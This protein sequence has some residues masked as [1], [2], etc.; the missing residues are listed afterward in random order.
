LAVNLEDAEMNA[1]KPP[2][3]KRRAFNSGGEFHGEEK[4][5]PEFFFRAEAAWEA[6]Y[7]DCKDAKKSIWVEQYI[8]LNDRAG[9][10]F[11][12][13]FAEKAQEG[14]EVRVVLDG[15]GSRALAKD[16]VAE[17]LR[18]AGVKLR[19]YHAVGWR[20]FL[21]PLRCLP[22]T[23][24]K[25]LL[26]DDRVAWTGSACFREEMR[27]WHE[28]GARFTGP[29]VEAVR[30]EQE[31]FWRSLL[32]GKSA[33]EKRPGK[34]PL[35]YFVS[36]PHF[37][38]S[39]IYR[40]LV[41]RID[42]AKSHIRVAAPY[43]MPP[44]RLRK[45]LERAAARGVRVDVLLSAKTDVKLA[46]CV[47]RVYIPRLLQ[48]GVR[49]YL[50][51]DGVLHAKFV[52]VDGLFAAVGSVNLD[53][54]S[55]TRNREASLILQGY[56]DVRHLWEYSNGYIRRA[57]RIDLAWWRGLPYIDKLVGRIGWYAREIL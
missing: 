37:G 39:Y 54:L 56:D 20:K 53:Y 21:H 49:L 52:L 24:V 25:T 9:R 12:D 33:P 7:V 28:L 50:H 3:E 35:E 40:E 45:A 2:E 44:R 57:R 47:S 42:A 55:L 27:S 32:R 16:P 26:V 5:R 8:L 11:L 1:G 6:M 31:R 34:G 4:H 19:F 15:I 30:A 10:R 17:K 46:D 36:E 13:V 18:Q 38:T 14:V 29:A 43:F 41:R 22:R 23:H 48:K 51:Q